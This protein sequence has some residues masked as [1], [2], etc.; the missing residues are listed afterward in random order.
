MYDRSQWL[1]LSTL[2]GFANETIS[3]IIYYFAGAAVVCCS[4]CINYLRPK[5]IAIAKINKSTATHLRFTS[6]IFRRFL[7][8]FSSICKYMYFV[9]IMHTWCVSTKCTDTEYRISFITHNI[10]I[11]LHYTFENKFIT[12]CINTCTRSV[13]FEFFSFF[14]FVC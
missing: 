11:Y 7:F 6:E 12:V 1:E 4:F 3:F 14:L 9:L 10:P 5:Q 13:Y 2:F 8:S